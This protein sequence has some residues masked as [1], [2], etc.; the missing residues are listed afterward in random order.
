[1]SVPWFDQLDV[2]TGLEP[3]ETGAIV[4]DVVEGVA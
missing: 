2:S 4:K 3:E 1:M